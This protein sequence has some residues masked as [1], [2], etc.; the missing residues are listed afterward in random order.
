MSW[1]ISKLSCQHGQRW[2]NRARVP[3]GLAHPGPH[4]PTA[5]PA[6]GF[7]FF[8]GV[9]GQDGIGT[10]GSELF[11]AEE[12]GTFTLE[13]PPQGR[14]PAEKEERV[15]GPQQILRWRQLSQGPMP[16]PPWADGRSD[17]RG[18]SECDLSLSLAQ[19]SVQKGS[20]I[21]NKCL[22]LASCP[23]HS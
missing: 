16:D 19:A 17:V 18:R 13:P 22:H 20:S 3:L 21:L 9:A 1:G 2:V 5:S 4:G 15:Y 23:T 10:P 6:L 14:L 12:Q 8:G 11:L 7:L